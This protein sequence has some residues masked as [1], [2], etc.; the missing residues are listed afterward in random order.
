MTHLWTYTLNTG[1]M[2]VSCPS[3]HSVAFTETPPW[4]LPLSVRWGFIDPPTAIDSSSISGDGL[5]FGNTL[6]ESSPA[7]PQGDFLCYFMPRYNDTFNAWVGNQS[8][9]VYAATEGSESFLSNP[10]YRFPRLAWLNDT[11]TGAAYIYHQ[12]NRSMLMED[13]YVVN[14]GW[15]STHISIQ[16][17]TWGDKAHASVNMTD[18]KEGRS[19]ELE[20]ESSRLVLWK[21]SM[22]CGFFTCSPITWWSYKCQSLL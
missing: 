16:T 2:C 21:F 20:S 19:T 9:Y 8:L 12:F 13:A 1:Q 22:P 3:C 10:P 5:S 11:I 18:Q 7:L 17:S 4:N 15:E 6:S 14:F